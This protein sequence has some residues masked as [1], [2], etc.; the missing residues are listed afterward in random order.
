MEPSEQNRPDPDELLKRIQKDEVE[1]TQGKLKIFFG[2]CAGVGK[3]YT[4]LEA[5][6]KAKEEK[7]NVVVGIV[8]THK[9]TETEGL[10][11]GLEIVPLKEIN[12][13]GTIFKEMD[14]DAILARQPSLVLVDELAHSNIP[15]SRHNKRYQDVLELLNNGINV[16]TTLNVQHI[17]SRTDTVLQITGTTIRET[18]PDSVFDRADDIELVDITPDE[19][20]QRLSEGKV[21]TTEKSRQAIQN[22][23]RKGNLTALREMA[24]RIAAERID[25]DVLDYKTEKR[26]DATWKSGQRLMVAIGPSP[27]SANLIRWT[28]RLAYSMEAPWIALYIE[29]DLKI[30]DEK[31]KIISDNFNL[32][33]ELGAEVIMI[34]STEVINALIRVARE[35]NVTQIVIGK[36]RRPYIL[37][38]SFRKDLVKELLKKS[39]DIDVYIVGGER[40]DLKNLFKNLLFIPQSSFKKYI[41]AIITVFAISLICY[42]FR[43]DIGYQSISLIFLL[44]LAIMPLFNFGRGPI[45]LT[46]LLSAFSWD[47]FFIPPQFTLAIAKVED[48]LM[49][50]MYFIVATVTG[51][52]SSKIRTQQMFLRQREKRIISLFNL[53]KELSAAVG[54]DDIAGI[55]VKKIEQTFEAKSAVIFYESVNKLSARSCKASTIANEDIE[56]NIA[57]WVFLNGQKAGKYTNTL[58]SA[59]ISY[60]PLKSKSGSLGVVALKY[61][62]DETPSF[63]HENLLENFISQIT[64]AVEREYLNDYAK[65]SLIADE[66]EKLYKTL[67]NSISHELKTPI[68]TIM[69]AVS[70]F[71]DEKIFQNKNV[72]KK[73]IE[74]IDIA[75]ERLNRLVENL[76]D[77]ARLE[78]GN[79]K[80]KLD[81]HSIEDLIHSVLEKLHDELD[82]HIIKVNIQ[83]DI[84][85]F[86]FDYALLEQALV[87]IVHNSIQYTPAG[88]EIKIEVR[89]INYRCLILISDNGRG[90][91]HES[92]DKLFDKFYRIPGTKA[93][94]T[95]LGLSIAKGFIE[96]HKGTI[97]AANGDNGGAVFT[98]SIPINILPEPK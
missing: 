73:F 42:A 55:A 81:Y 86:K 88:S 94:G 80:L 26:I 76:L 65:K 79:L 72:W 49:L 38:P 98:V 18:V 21:Y 85:I 33:K 75:A 29:N 84:E 1:S 6:H 96:A 91:P 60:Y 59:A 35:N 40:K 68:T 43:L 92:L 56:W 34:Q 51:T 90:F 78:S 41:Q 28:R 23:F 87:N 70:S 95:G 4:M 3:T 2:M 52:L 66:S 47:Y 97:S 22:F 39:G 14:L 62:D 12:Y 48:F 63:E 45:L 31:K 50:I 57:Q 16:Y 61:K 5:A 9:R 93:G 53:S 69:G 77:M 13:R 46:A 7:I 74:E 27:Y 15:G 17:E 20:L 10:L 67:F 24:L 36:S 8:E 64:N 71:K 37:H 25:K 82:G 11:Q 54:L 58:M 32:A 83:E 44:F 89:A 30:S 19:L